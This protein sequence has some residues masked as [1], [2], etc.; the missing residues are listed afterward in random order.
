[1]AL[2]RDFEK[3]ET[4]RVQLDRVE[5]E[6]RSQIRTMT[7][8]SGLYLTEEEKEDVYKRQ[9]DVVIVNSIFACRIPSIFSSI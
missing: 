9:S 8:L 1:M 3:A 4:V 7:E 2:S 5:Q 6:A